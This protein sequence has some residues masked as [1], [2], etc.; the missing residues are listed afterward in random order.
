MR[1]PYYVILAGTGLQ[2]ER[3]E[4]HDLLLDNLVGDWHVERKFG[5]GRHGR[6]SNRARSGCSAILFRRIA[7]IASSEDAGKAGNRES[8][9]RWAKKNQCRARDREQLRVCD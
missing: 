5:G 8:I 6:E 4:F 9:W 3:A 2:A 7:S 1:S